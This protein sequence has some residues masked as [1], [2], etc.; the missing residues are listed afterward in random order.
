MLEIIIVIS[1]IILD[2]ITKYIAYMNLR[3]IPSQTIPLIN[4]V[5]H[6]TYAENRGAA[7]S[8]LQNRRW[9][10]VIITILFIIFAVYYLI[11]H[12]KGSTLIKISISLILAGACGNLIDRIRNGYVVDFLDFRL[13][14][15]PIFNVA[16]SA[17]VIGS[18][19]LAY[20]L[21]FIDGKKGVNGK[22]SN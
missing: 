15:F 5:F 16:D 12:R 9:F 11:T 20:Y 4:G 14:N 18:I 8:I 2:Q 21:I 19:L 7:F 3:T 6:L 13:I 22:D 17:V 1:V 10:F